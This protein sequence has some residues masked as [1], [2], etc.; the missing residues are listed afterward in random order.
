MILNRLDHV[1][2]SLATAALVSWNAH[3]WDLRR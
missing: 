3:E 2:D 1:S